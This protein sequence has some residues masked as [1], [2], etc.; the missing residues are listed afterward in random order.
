[1]S[2]RVIAQTN[3]FSRDKIEKEY[4]NIDTVQNILD[5]LKIDFKTHLTYIMVNDNKISDVTTKVYD[6]D[7]VL[8][9]VMPT[10]DNPI[11]EGIPSAMG[12]ITTFGV[13]VSDFLFNNALGNSIDTGNGEFNILLGTVL[14]SVGAPLAS[15][16]PLIGIPLTYIGGALLANGSLANNAGA[17]EIKI[18]GQSI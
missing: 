18:N 5:D 15:V 14:S 13:G 11:S 6:E 1:M 7:L 16:M 10:G 12:D 4:I 3:I 9:K 17:T 8:I 2:T